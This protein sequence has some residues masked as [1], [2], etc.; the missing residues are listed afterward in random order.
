MSDREYRKGLRKSYLIAGFVIGIALTIYVVQ[1]TVKSSQEMLEPQPPDGYKP[2]IH[3]LKQASNTNGIFQFA[4]TNDNP[5]ILQFW[6]FANF[7][8]DKSVLLS[9]KN[10]MIGIAER[11]IYLMKG[12]YHTSTSSLLLDKGIY[13]I[14][15]QYDLD[16]ADL[17]LYTNIQPVDNAFIERMRKLDKG[18][19]ENAPEGYTQ[20]FVTNLVDETMDTNTIYSITPE[21]PGNYY[22]SFYTSVK[23]GSVSLKLIGPS[24]PGIELVNEKHTLSDQVALY[25]RQ[26]SAYS[27]VF[28]CSSFT[29]KV[30]VYTKKK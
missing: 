2:Y 20:L 1:A 23:E 13:P 3:V 9:S 16:E 7:K 24:Y 30:A 5:K 15:I 6:L 12:D 4:Y 28:A 14:T 8:G 19:L 11:D 18:Y 26:G 27:I 22:F 17:Y 25:L 10:K 29:G 21:Q